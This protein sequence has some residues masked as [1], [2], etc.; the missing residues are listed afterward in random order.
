MSFYVMASTLGQLT[1]SF[2]LA[3][4]PKDAVG[5][6]ERLRG[7]GNLAWLLGWWLRD[8]LLC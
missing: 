6:C 3:H 8:W 2:D 1:N 5:I 4:V 7:A